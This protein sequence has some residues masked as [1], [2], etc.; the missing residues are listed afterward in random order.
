MLSYPVFTDLPEY[1]AVWGA[2]IP[3]YERVKPKQNN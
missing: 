1:L 2:D 3:H